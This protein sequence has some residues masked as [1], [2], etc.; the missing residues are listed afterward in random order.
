[1]K[2]RIHFSIIL[3]FNC[4]IVFGQTELQRKI[5]QYDN[6]DFYNPERGLVKQSSIR[7]NGGSNYANSGLTKSYIE[8]NLVNKKISIIWRYYGLQDWH[9][10]PIPQEFLQILN[11]DLNVCRETGIKIIPRFIYSSSTSTNPVDADINQVMAHLDQIEPIFKNNADVI[12][13][14]QAG[15]IGAWGEWAYSDY[16]GATGVTYKDSLNMSKRRK[17]IQRLLEIMPESRTISIRYPRDKQGCTYPYLSV[18]SDTLTK[19]TAFSGDYKARVGY[20]NDSYLYD[21]SDRG[22]YIPSNQIWQMREYVI[23]DSKYLPFG[24]ETSGFV[25]DKYYKPTEVFKWCDLFNLSYLHDIYHPDVVNYWKQNNVWD[26]LVLRLGYRFHLKEGFF[27]PSVKIGE[28]FQYK[29]VIENQGFT[30]PFNPR[31]CELVFIGNDKTIRKKINTDPRHWREGTTIVEGNILIDNQFNSGSYDIYLNLPD[32][33]P[34]L[35]TD[36]RYSI[37]LANKNAWDGNKGYN[38][39]NFSVSI[40]ENSE[41]QSPVISNKTASVADNVANG[42]LVTTVSGSDPD[43][44]QTL[45]YAI[46]AGNTNNAFNINNSG[47]IKVNNAS[48][49]PAI[50]SFGLTVEVSD[51]GS[52]V[53]SATATVTINISH[54]NDPPVVNNKTV[55]ILE[56]ISNGTVVTTVSANDP[57]IGQTLTY[58]IVSGNTSNAFTIDN[59]GKIVVNNASVLNSTS[60]FIL[61]VKVTDNGSPVLSS[62]GTITID[63]NQ[64]NDPPVINNKSASVSDDALNGTLVTTVSASDPDAGQTLTYSIT[65]GNTDTAFYINNSGQIEINNA[66]ALA[67][68]NAFNLSVRVSDNGNPALSATAVI[69]INVNH[70]NDAPVINNKTASV[71]DDV[72]TGTLVTTIAATDPDVGQALIFEIISGNTNSAFSIDNTGKIKVSNLNSLKS[73]NSFN[74]SVRVSDNGSPS[75]SSSATVTINVNHVNDPPQ[76]NNQQVTIPG[77]LTNGSFVL[78]IAVSD[79]D[80]GQSLSYRIVSGNQNNAFT[81]NNS[82]N[83]IVNNESALSTANSFS[84]NVEVSDNG[85]PVMKSGATMTI[86]VDQSGNTDDMPAAPGNM[87]IK[88]ENGNVSLWWLDNSSNEDNFILQRKVNSGSF[89]NL[90]TLNQNITVFTDSDLTDGNYYEYRVCAKNTAGNSTWSNICSVNYTDSSLYVLNAPSN[91]DYEITGVSVRVTWSDNSNNESQFVIEKTD[92]NFNTVSIDSVVA[93]TVEYMDNNIQPG[94]VIQYRVQ[95]VNNLFTSG[96]SDM[97]QVELIESIDTEIFEIPGNF[98]VD[99]FDDKSIR[100]TWTFQP[101][102]NVWFVIQKVDYINQELKRIEITGNELQ[103]TDIDIQPSTTYRYRIM[104]TNGTDSSLYTN[105]LTITSAQT[106]N[107]LENSNPVINGYNTQNGIIELYLS[108]SSGVEDYVVE[109]SISDTLNFFNIGTTSANVSI[110]KD[111]MQSQDIFIYYRIKLQ[112]EDFQSGYSEI[113]QVINPYVIMNADIDLQGELTS[114]NSYR[115]NWNDMPGC[116]HYRIYQKAA[117]DDQFQVLVDE[118]EG[119]NFSGYLPYGDFDGISYKVAACFDTMILKES[120]IISLDRNLIRQHDNFS[121]ENYV[122]A[123]I[124]LSW[125]NSIVSPDSKITLYR[126]DAGNTNYSV[127]ASTFEN[128]FLDT[129]LQANTSYSY[130][131][132]YL[133]N[134]GSMLVTSEQ[135]TISTNEFMEFVTPVIDSVD[136]ENL[137]VTIIWSDTSTYNRTYR[138]ERTEN[139]D[140]GFEPLSDFT[141]NMEFVDNNVES[142]K[143]YFY[144][145]ISLVESI[146]TVHGPFE[147]VYVLSEVDAERDHQG[148]VAGYNFYSADDQVNDISNYDKPLDLQF[149]DEDNSK[150][151]S[152]E[153]V[154]IYAST[155]PADKVLESIKV[156]SEFSMECWIKS[157]DTR[158]LG[159]QQIVSIEN[160]TD[161]LFVLYQDNGSGSGVYD[162]FVNFRTN[163]TNIEGKPDFYSNAS[164]D[165]QTVHHLVYSRSKDGT[166]KIYIDGKL[167]NTNVR[168]SGLNDWIGDYYITVGGSL[169]GFQLWKGNMYYLAVYNTIITPDQIKSNYKVGPYKGFH[170]ERTD[171]SID[172]YP[173]PATDYIEVHLTPAMDFNSSEKV[174]LIIIN[175]LGKLVSEQVLTDPSYDQVLEINVSDYKPGIYTVYIMGEGWRKAK[176]VVMRE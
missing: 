14:W 99:A 116:A 85:S 103:F 59:S 22:T 176:R 152:D 73:N 81:I 108:G 175:Q 141:T 96:F 97:I 41:N 98:N 167:Q 130:Y 60:S 113:V 106:E 55:T 26:S 32:P 100:L 107:P 47:Q 154:I 94:D 70:V 78:T 104:A 161:K 162:Y 158:S 56:N 136:I 34:T 123:S 54:V 9:N 17:I 105:Y 20:Y 159:F 134:E 51:N 39:L 61:S 131:F 18:P 129:G 173:N 16:Y 124:R 75:L 52:P 135:L 165:Y 12:L 139:P 68:V 8:S 57:D 37:R 44:G 36:P 93:N 156:T 88:S 53:L 109:R 83:V 15:F 115:L 163:S 110:Y 66:T 3:I 58:A 40:S 31:D 71:S 67:A 170:A 148:M 84:L 146:W 2:I 171:I 50:N 112:S 77:D 79:P 164:F 35:N 80:I 82:G 72:A 153:E 150:V 76:V 24:G 137:A 90:I 4:I 23:G 118:H 69:T 168:P 144:R 21:D 101:V 149:N 92:M 132:E 30:S 48:A 147:Q 6:S 151:G 29:F 145:V 64:V 111:E 172:V 89:S 91:L 133:I 5:Y 33:E 45:A 11:N 117:F 74:L 128:Q 1:M 155:Y 114:H 42:T 143:I 28:N 174:R 127:L 125:D 87:N 102:E 121:A 119:L 65:S 169:N 38:N 160:N 62:T 13:T 27:S 157:T 140:N 25:T 142:G 46:T 126:T 63:V 7:Y 166:E 95:A 19:N 86:F 122:N 10:K 43:A 49:L 138:V 120:E